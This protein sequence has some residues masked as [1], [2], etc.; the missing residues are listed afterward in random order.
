MSLAQEAARHE[1]ESAAVDPPAEAQ[2]PDSSNSR[3][4]LSDARVA[5]SRFEQ[6]VL[7]QGVQVAPGILHV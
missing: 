5:A 7:S 6:S 4:A 1:A 3:M 2:R